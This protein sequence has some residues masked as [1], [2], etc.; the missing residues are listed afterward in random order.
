MGHLTPEKIQT[1]SERDKKK[2]KKIQTDSEREKRKKKEFKNAYLTPLSIK[3][4]D[5]C[6]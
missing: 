3:G 6:V 4:S 2:K 1:G 5:C